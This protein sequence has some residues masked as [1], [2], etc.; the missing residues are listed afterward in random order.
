MDELDGYELVARELDHGEV[1]QVGFR[2]L[3]HDL[4]SQARVE[5]ERAI[6]IGDTEADMQGPHRG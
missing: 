6:A 2:Y 1:P 3:A 4:V 5:G